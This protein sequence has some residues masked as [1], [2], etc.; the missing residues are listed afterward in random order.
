MRIKYSIERI[1]KFKV[2]I[3]ITFLVNGCFIANHLVPLNNIPKPTGVYNVGTQIFEWKDEN[4]EEWFTD[5]KT[6]KRRLMVQVWYPT[7]DK[8]TNYI[9]YLDFPKKRIAP[10]SQRVGLPKYLI[11][12]IKNVKS[13]SILNASVRVDSNKYPLV[14]FSHGLGGMRMQNSV[15]MEELASKGYMVI[16]MDH[17]YDAYVTIYKDG[18]IAEFRSWLRDDASEEEFWNVR[19]PQINTRSQDVSFIIDK[20]FD[21]K[22]NGNKFWMNINL[23]KI[24]VMGHSYG[25][26]TSILSAYNDKRIAACINLDG[27]MEPIIPE[28]IRNGINIPFLYIGQLKWDDTPLNNIKLDSLVNSSNGK[29]ILI[30]ETKHFDYSDTPHFSPLAVKFG[31]AGTIDMDILRNQINSEIIS[32]FDLHLK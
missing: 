18:S 3:L 26:A 25:G 7:L 2:I 13:N 4:R 12:H 20:V 8:D 6:D 10:L 29:K 28:V 17:A 24:G 31:L 11:Q 15:Q 16:A 19:L 9:N 1:I 30:P 14:I 23:S 22:Q 21:L 5:I 32:F 27:W